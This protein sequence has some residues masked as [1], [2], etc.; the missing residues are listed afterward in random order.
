VI[1]AMHVSLNKSALSPCIH[2]LYNINN[3]SNK[4]VYEFM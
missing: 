1:I 4:H 3:S 2:A